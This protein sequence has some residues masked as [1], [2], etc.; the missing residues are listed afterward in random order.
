MSAAGR[1][2]RRPPVQPALVRKLLPILDRFPSAEP[3]LIGV[4]GG[5][6]S[7]VLLHA[8]Q[9]W[10]GYRRLI[11]CHLDHAVRE[12]SNA[13]AAFVR[14]LAEQLGCAVEVA[15]LDVTGLARR[16]KLSL[17]TAAREAR[18]GFFAEVAARRACRTLF[19]GHHAEDRVETLL[20]NLFRGTG[21][22][23]LSAIKAIRERR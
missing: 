12:E 13:D 23:G 16:R 3:Y 6:D 15:R 9:H 20:F 18:Y 1:P 19:L 21:G 5:R 11:V 8:L 10:L 2:K 22:S 4:S 14:Q 7:V 17:E